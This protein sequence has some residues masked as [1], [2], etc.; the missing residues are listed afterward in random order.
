MGPDAIGLASYK[1]EYASEDISDIHRFGTIRVFRGTPVV[2][3]RQSFVD[4]NNE[5]VW[6][7]PQYAYV[8]PTGREKVV[9][10]VMEGQ[11]QMYDFTNRDQS[12]EVMTYRKVGVGILAY[13]NWGIYQNTGISASDWYNG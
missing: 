1:A 4:E 10:V 2:E 6:I 13:N 5:K 3:L 7:H 9:K 11:T 8:L 12:I